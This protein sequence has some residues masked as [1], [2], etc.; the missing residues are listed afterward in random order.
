[1]LQYHQLH[2]RLKIGVSSRSP[3]CMARDMIER[4]HNVG[5]YN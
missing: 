3:M 4:E 2:H 5:R 1:V